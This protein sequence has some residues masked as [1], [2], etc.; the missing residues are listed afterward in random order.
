MSRG[1]FAMSIILEANKIP[2]DLLEYF[3][4]VENTKSSV[5]EINTRPFKQAHFAVF[6]P[7]LPERCIKAG[8]PE[9]GIVLDPFMGS[10][11][12]LMV[13]KKLNRSFIG[14]DLNPKYIEIAQ[15]RINNTQKSMF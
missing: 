6:P 9:G 11:T 4:P 10:G 1:D 5:F 13:A 7:E 3:E 12:T 14:I 2:V 8:C 15:K